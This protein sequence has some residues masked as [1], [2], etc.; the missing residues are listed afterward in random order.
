MSCIPNYINCKHFN[1]SCM[2]QWRGKCIYILLKRETFK[3]KSCLKIKNTE[4]YI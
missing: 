2:R 3:T 1:T 4:K